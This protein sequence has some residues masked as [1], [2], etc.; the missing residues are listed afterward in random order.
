MFSS[1]NIYRLSIPAKDSSKQDKNELLNK[2][3]KLSTEFHLI[4][5]WYIWYNITNI[6][7]NAG[8]GSV[9]IKWIMLGALLSETGHRQT[10]IVLEA[11]KNINCLVFFKQS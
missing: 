10:A 9:W 3:F 6:E 2:L 5:I 1:K 7:C 8:A 4:Y 11:Q